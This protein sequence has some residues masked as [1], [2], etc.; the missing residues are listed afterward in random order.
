MS[1]SPVEYPPQLAVGVTRDRI[2]GVSPVAR[3]VHRAILHRFATEGR[4]PDRVAL[5]AAAPAGHGLDV[6]LAELHDRDVIRLDQT[7]RIGAAYPFSATPT[8]HLVAIGG[9]PTVYAMCAVDALGMAAMLDRDI[10]ITSTDPTSGEPVA[11]SIRDGQASWRP[12][13]TVVFVGSATPAIAAG[14]CCPPAGAADQ[15]CAAPAAERC[16]TTMNFFTDHHT[17]QAW[18]S[19]HPD[20]AGTVLN[21]RQALALGT[22]IF[23]HLLDE[24]PHPDP[25]Q[26]RP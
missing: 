16:C 17:A 20:A 18:R 3:A 10:A 12:P 25:P 24:H 5:A 13:T 22:D 21:G 9:G 7:G 23:G 19:A 2:R 1:T 15:A 4:A 8:P 14:D 11:V 6:M 26:E